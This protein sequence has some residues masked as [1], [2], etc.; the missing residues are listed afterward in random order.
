MITDR[1]PAADYAGPGANSGIW[2]QRWFELYPRPCLLLGRR[3]QVLTMNGAAKALL[4]VET[5]LQLREGAV[6]ARDRK[7][8][9]MLEEAVRQAPLGDPMRRILFGVASTYVLRFV[10]LGCD[11]DDPVALTLRS[12]DQ[13]DLL[14]ADLSEPFG[15]TQGEQRIVE[16]LLRGC[17][18]QEIADAMGK[19]VLTVRTHIKR[20]YA[21]LS[22]TTREQLFARLLPFLDT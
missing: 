4:E 16:R 15:M 14:C 9:L 13:E 10:A 7:A 17:S 6:W 5:A 21:K 12:T 2:T 3:L 1:I 19:S 22:V 18:S 8:H 11:E 20:A